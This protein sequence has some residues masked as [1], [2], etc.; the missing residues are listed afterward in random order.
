MPSG[1]AQFLE[2]VLDPIGRALGPDAA[3][4]VVALRADPEAQCRIDEL[5][6]K[7]NE[8]N[9]TPEERSE[10]E[11]LLAAATVIG[12]LQAKARAILAGRKA[13]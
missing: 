7:A 12:V 8:G 11:S 4:R 10:Y 3:Q 2:R 1:S 9:L 6:D 13:D 5:A